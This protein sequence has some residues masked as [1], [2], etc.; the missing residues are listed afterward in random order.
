[1]TQTVS[2]S[3]PGDGPVHA[4][5]LLALPGLSALG[6]AEAFAQQVCAALSRAMPFSGLAPDEARALC[7]WMTV[8]QAEAGA[9]LLKEDD[10]AEFMLVILDGAVELLRRNRNQFPAQLA[11][12]AAGES[13]GE[14]SM[15]DRAPRFASCV[16]LEPT[17]FAV[18][19]RA[20]LEALAERSPTLA[21]HLLTGWAAM[22]SE[23][24]REVGARLFTQLEAARAA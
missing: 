8:H 6:P 10:P 5:A 22:L 13:V 14:M 23:R 11:V 12:A 19:T 16:A 18:L 24:L 2:E 1:M 3:L 7:A 15:F 9:T 17:R 20:G 21:T 4:P